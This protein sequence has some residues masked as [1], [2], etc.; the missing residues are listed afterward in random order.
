MEEQRHDRI[1]T[2]GSSPAGEPRVGPL[3]SRMERGRLERQ[4]QKTAQKQFGLAFSGVCVLLV[5]AVLIVVC[6]PVGS[7]IKDLFFARQSPSGSMVGGVPS[8]WKEPS[9]QRAPSSEASN[10]LSSMGFS[11]ELESLPGSLISSRESSSNT[12]SRDFS[13]KP[14]SQASS[15]SPISSAPPSKPPSSVPSSSVPSSSQ[16]ESNPQPPLTANELPYGTDPA[17]LNQLLIMGDRVA[18][19]QQLIN[20]YYKNKQ[21]TPPK[22][23]GG[24]TLGD[25]VEAY[26]VEGYQEGVRGDVAFCQSIIETGW[27]QFTGAVPYTKNNFC[28]LGAEDADPANRSL[29][30]ETMRQ[31]VKA[32]IQYLK[33]YAEGS[34]THPYIVPRTPPSHIKGKVRYWTGLS[35]KY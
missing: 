21:N 28:G 27:F 18:S 2:T 22:L 3:P 6:T 7:Q 24:A 20:L 26:L 12:P 19:K 33:M 29:Q 17:D 13:S 14:S 30:F 23:T 34:T 31:G 35:G 4:R 1:E 15:S 5:T 32:H 9:S 25:L 10:G 8:D 16:P 11:S